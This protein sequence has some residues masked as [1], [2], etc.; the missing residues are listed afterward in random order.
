MN[1]VIEHKER[2]NKASKLMTEHDVSTLLITPGA[3]LR[4]LTGYKAK[5]LERLTC[6]ILQ[7]N[8]SPK[9]IVPKL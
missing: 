7:E 4:Y 3:N 5:N 6:L 2:L 8:E 1:L 9:L